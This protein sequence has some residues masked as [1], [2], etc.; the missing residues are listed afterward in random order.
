[1]DKL[2]LSDFPL[3]TFDK[4][5]YA[6]MDRQGHV[7]NAV[8][9]TCLETGRVEILYRPDSPL[10]A[11]EASFVIVSLQLDF[12]QEINWPGRVDIGTG[13]QKIGTSSITFYQK[14]FQDGKCVAQAKTVVVHVGNVQNKSIP[15]SEHTR[16]ALNVW[17]LPQDQD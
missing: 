11:P 7:N 12:I 10:H 16:I 1:M 2:K 3:Q 15:L 14:L 6:D 17:L 9:L 8:F 5:R 13:I 4:V